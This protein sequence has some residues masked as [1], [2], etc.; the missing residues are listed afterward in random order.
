MTI[1]GGIDMAVRENAL[2]ETAKYLKAQDE[3]YNLKAQKAVE[4]A[5]NKKEHFMK[6]Y[7]GILESREARERDRS[8]IRE[9]AR[10]AALSSCLK[11]IYIT[12]LEANTLTSDGIVL[13]EN[14]VDS[15]IQEN[16]GATKI[17][18]KCP[19]NTYLLSTLRKIVED[20]ADKETEDIEKS[21]KDDEKE[22]KDNKSKKD[23]S[24]KDLDSDPLGN[25]S[26]D[27]DDD[28]DSKDDEKEEEDDKKDDLEERKKKDK[29][30]LDS[31]PLGDTDIDDNSS[32]DEDDEEEE[33]VPDDLDKDVSQSDEGPDDS[34]GNPDLEDDTD[35]AAASPEDDSPDDYTMDDD[36]DNDESEAADDV[37][38]GIDP[39]EPNSVDGPGET[40]Q[41]RM[42]DELEKEEDVQKAV[43]LIRQRVSDAEEAFIKRNAE[44]KKK[45]E[46]LL[47]K[48]SDNVKT[49]E[50]L[51][52]NDSTKSSEDTDN[53]EESGEAKVAEEHVRMYKKQIK[54]ISENRPRTVF[55]HMVRNL[56]TDVVKDSNLKEKYVTESGQF[57]MPAFME[58]AKVMYGFLETINTI[59]LE[60][61][62]TKYIQ[63]V[64]DNM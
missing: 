62:D 11:A 14:M 28:T 63:K 13:A 7:Y 42:F 40:N 17:F 47:G 12:A 54:E 29:E 25:P 51:S 37:I 36:P 53:E 56:M 43:E 45:V 20:A 2:R 50:D 19:N 6:N 58:S 1:K 38:A 4:E 24:G 31:D 5:T 9:S 18:N 46:D 48:I 61:V 27:I 64:L 8:R 55:E 32:A 44:D 23:L 39:N 15:W 59:Q 10:N 49:V 30:K 35:P 16:G 41:G 34:L 57:D 3:A 52:D 26:I 33:K 21:D 22:E 60:K